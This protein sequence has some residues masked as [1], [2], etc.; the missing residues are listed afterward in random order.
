[1]KILLSG[2]KGKIGK[3]ITKYFKHKKKFTLFYFKQQSNIFKKI[4]IVIDFSYC[5]NTMYLLKQC[6]KYKKKIIIGTTGF[7]QSQIYK[8]KKISKKI[9]VFFEYNMNKKFQKFINLL[10]FANLF[11]KTMDKYVI[12]SHRKKKKDIP[13]GSCINIL[14]TLDIKKYYSLR[15]GNVIG[16]HKVIFIDKY[17]KITISHSALNAKAYLIYLIKIICF[18]NKK[19]AGFYNIKHI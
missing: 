17:N 13:S 11:F 1:M 10:F 3:K 2:H 12:E 8:I 5:K 9:A 19:S 14:K 4:D 15:I 6:L 16:E 7:T 18:I